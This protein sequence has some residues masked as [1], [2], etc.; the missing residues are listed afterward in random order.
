MRL[1]RINWK[2]SCSLVGGGVWSDRD[3]VKK[4]KPSDIISVGW[5]IKENKKKIT[6][7]AHFSPYQASGELCIPKGCIVKIEELP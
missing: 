6:I 7:A 4:L 2:D 3:E 1:V 5:V